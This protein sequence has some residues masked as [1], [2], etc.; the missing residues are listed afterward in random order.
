MN[1]LKNPAYEF[2]W[3]VMSEAFIVHVARLALHDVF[4]H[5]CHFMVVS[6][7]CAIACLFQSCVPLPVGFSHV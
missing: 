7:I 4:S 6:V 5:I 3:G 1:K 2:A